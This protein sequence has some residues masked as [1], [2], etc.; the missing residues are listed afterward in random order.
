[1]TNIYV[2]GT[3]AQLP[4]ATTKTIDDFGHAIR[5][6][7]S[8]LLSGPLDCAIVR[9]EKASLCASEVCNPDPP[10]FAKL[11]TALAPPFETVQPVE[12]CLLDLFPD[13]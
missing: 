11:A 3:A 8:A 9:R 5:N 13:Q 4:P 12:M 2:S 7:D 10:E 6:A 1:M